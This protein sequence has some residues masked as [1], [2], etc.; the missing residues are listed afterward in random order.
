[1][2]GKKSVFR[3]TY[4]PKGKLNGRHF[5]SQTVF[6][7]TQDALADFRI[8]GL[9]DGGHEGIVFWAGRETA[10]ETHY[11][12]AIVPEA[13]HTAGSVFV[14]R[15]AF[16][17]AANIARSNGLGI[18]AQVHSHPGSDTR[19]SDGDDRLIILPFEGMLSLVAPSYGAELNTISDFG[20][21][22]FQNTRWV[23]CSPASV[24]SNLIQTI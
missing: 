23:L 19:H 12:L 16:A 9:D 6:R 13:E 18:L 22:Q 5:V 1:M 21:H 10:N 17:D 24:K 11:S 7:S 3:R 14:S 20:V 15:E 2:W 4:L 8:A